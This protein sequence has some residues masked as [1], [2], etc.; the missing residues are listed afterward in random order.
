MR[1]RET[2]CYEDFLG[3]EVCLL[4]LKTHQQQLF[5]QRDQVLSC[6]SGI[7]QAS[8]NTVSPVH[9]F[10]ADFWPGGARLAQPGLKDYLFTAALCVCLHV[11]GNHVRKD[12]R[13]QILQF[14]S[15]FLLCPKETEM[16]L[17][18]T[19]PSSVLPLPKIFET[20]RQGSLYSVEGLLFL[21]FIVKPTP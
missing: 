15:F 2:P 21:F 3:D 10:S 12:L 20:Q 16:T 14:G 19:S 8:G 9:Y 13:L 5:L 11:L 1:L 7:A 18:V 6:C 17:R 4:L